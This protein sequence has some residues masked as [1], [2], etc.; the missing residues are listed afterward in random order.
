MGFSPSLS[1]SFV[2]KHH[3]LTKF[4]LSPSPP[5]SAYDRNNWV[6]T[7]ESLA[8]KAALPADQVL[9]EGESS[10]GSSSRQA[11]RERD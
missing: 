9:I 7:P 4:V 10:L 8:M 5:Q 1:G 11:A 3:S 2:R 6:E